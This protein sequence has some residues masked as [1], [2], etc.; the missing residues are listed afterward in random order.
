MVDGEANEENL[1]KALKKISKK[2]FAHKVQEEKLET[3]LSE[4]AFKELMS[5]VRIDRNDYIKR[6]GP[7]IG[8]KVNTLFV[9]FY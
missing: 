8:D 2:G 7:T 1:K 3:K 5:K 4:K 6:Y 9:L